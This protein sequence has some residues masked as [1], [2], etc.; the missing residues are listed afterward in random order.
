MIQRVC[1]AG[2]SVLPQGQRPGDGVA[3]AANN[4]S[5][6]WGLTLFNVT[7]LHVGGQG[8]RAGCRCQ[9]GSRMASGQDPRARPNACMRS[10]INRYRQAW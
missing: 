3:D 2:V 6:D 5:P 7:H 1:P 9:L 4:T 8:R 10:L